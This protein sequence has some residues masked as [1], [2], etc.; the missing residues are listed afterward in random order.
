[1]PE[2]FDVV[3]LVVDIPE[4]GLRTGMQ[5]T[6]VECHPDDT[7]EVEFANESGETLDL[8]ALRPDQ[9][10]LIWQARTRKWLSIQDQLTSLIARL[11][12]EAR[13]EVLDFARYLYLRRQRQPA[14]TT[15]EP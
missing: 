7:Y 4:R 2:L 13:R 3:E 11:P 10:M 15:A 8:V 1:M 12:E 5:G 14:E 9:F 6:I